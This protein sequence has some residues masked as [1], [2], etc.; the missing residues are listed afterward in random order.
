MAGGA[1]GQGEANPVPRLTT[2]AVKLFILKKYFLYLPS[3][4]KYSNMLVGP[5]IQI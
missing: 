2:H 4:S 1:R 5:S 3:A